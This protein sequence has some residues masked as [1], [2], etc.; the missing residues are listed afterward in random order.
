MHTTFG[1]IYLPL[2]CTYR[3]A[4]ANH[5]DNDIFDIKIHC[6]IDFFVK[7]VRFIKASAATPSAIPIRKGDTFKA[8]AMLQTPPIRRLAQTQRQIYIKI[9]WF[10]SVG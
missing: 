9:K 4:H 7:S 3:T 10:H 8:T 1:S 5:G 2:R 6:F